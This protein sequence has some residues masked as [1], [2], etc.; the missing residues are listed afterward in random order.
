MNK[1]EI[2]TDTKAIASL[3][4]EAIQK[5]KQII[6]SDVLSVKAVED[7]LPKICQTVVDAIAA[8][9]ISLLASYKENQGSEHGYI[10]CQQDFEPEEIVQEF[11]LL[12]QIILTQLQPYLLSQS[13]QQII[14]QITL[15]DLIINRI[16]ENA[17]Y[18]FNIA[19]KQQQEILHQQMFLT[20]R[21]LTRSVENR[22]ENLSYLVHEIKNP[23]TSIIGYSDLFLRQQQNN[24]IT[25]LEHIQQ[26]LQQGRKVLRL[27]NDT[28]EISSC[29][30]G[31]FKLKIQQINICTL[32]ENITLGLKPCLKAKKLKL[33]TSCVPKP[34]TIRSD[35][36]RL[37]QIITNLLMNAIRYTS[38]GK[39][40][41][42][43]C[44]LPNSQLAIEISDTGVGISQS[45][46]KHIFK[47]YFRSQ[48]SRQ[49]VP[50]GV[51]LGLAIVAQLVNI[52]EGK[53]E[54]VSEVN[55]GSTFIVTIPLNL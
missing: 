49:N 8:N 18:S 5:D 13:P 51:G 35:S 14:K 25:N 4:I 36:L 31:N 32:I 53:I 3:L 22:Q 39:I 6:S 1:N 11:F 44:L 26:V 9:N 46:Q 24:S 45:E 15:I 37:Q 55:L 41:L 2:T 43:C 30:R 7:N 12:K 16:V 17:L 33:I 20:N 52:L 29:K 47:P 19:R 42:N 40:E 34:L 54:L 48:K 38:Q 10:R 50:E 23:L 28:T 27:V 21:E